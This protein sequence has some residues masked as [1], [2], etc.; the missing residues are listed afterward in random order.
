MSKSMLDLTQLYPYILKNSVRDTELLQQLREETSKDEMARMQIAPEQG[1][2]MALLAKLIGTK[3]ALEV[4]TFTGYSS[5]SVGLALPEDGELIC[6]DVNEKWTNVAKR[7]WQ[8][9][10]I[11]QKITLIVAPA[12]TTLNNLLA[13]GKYNYFDFIFIDADKENY[14]QYYELGL[15]LLRPNGLMLLDNMLWAGRVIDAAYAN[16]I[17][18]QAIVALNKKLHTDERI[19]ISLIPVADGISVIR[20][21]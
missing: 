5:L 11:S 2:L 17:D 3:R 9:A 16:D 14:D 1:Q 8:A 15:K 13:E 21:R 7:Y 12:V 10:N 4:G 6:C 20:K 18:T 19:D